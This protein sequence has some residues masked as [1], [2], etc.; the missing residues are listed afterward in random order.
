MKSRDSK[1][2]SGAGGMDFSTS[3]SKA[4]LPEIWSTKNGIGGNV[5]V[6]LFSWEKMP[7]VIILPLLRIY[8]QQ[9]WTSGKI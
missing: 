4:L 9:L 7:T 6:L 5:L 3:H 1:N 8:I 2:V